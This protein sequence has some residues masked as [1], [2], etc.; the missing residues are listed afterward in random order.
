MPP[1]AA[2]PPGGGGNGGGFTPPPAQ[3][4]GG[5]GSGEMPQLEVGAA[6]GYG[7]KK[8]TENVGPFIVL[9]LAVLVAGLVVGFLQLVLTPN[10]TSFFLSWVLSALLGAVAYVIMAIVQ[11]G[12]L[13]AGLGVT[14]GE[15][16]EVSQLTETT[17]IAQY[18]ITNILVGLGFFIGFALCFIPGL[19]WLI[20]TA[21]APLLALDKG[22]EPVEAIK[23]SINW[24]KERFGQVFLILLVV[25]IVYIIGA[26]F[27]GVG[28]L[29]TA[30]VALLAIVYSYRA[31]NNE[32][33]TP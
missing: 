20:L 24:V 33:V 29:V 11:A 10:D 7:W 28:I 31:L 19:I 32:L 26:C 14:R 12:V 30:P 15:K 2:T 4:Y 16:P 17:N 23:T 3:P 9:M 22:M 6:I 21:Y 8:F 1:P 13:R 18:I 27:F 25:H 5:G